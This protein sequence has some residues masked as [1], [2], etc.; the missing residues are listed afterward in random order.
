MGRSP[1]ADFGRA[2]R[3]GRPVQR[4]AACDADRP[5]AADE[6]VSRMVAIGVGCRAGVK[7][8]TIAELVW[9]ALAQTRATEGERRMVTLY[10]KAGQPG[11]IEAPRP[12]R[13]VLPPL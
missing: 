10:A 13:P 2:R 9:R 12:I 4:L 7:A 8:E 1:L 11:V 5:V 3:A 6:T